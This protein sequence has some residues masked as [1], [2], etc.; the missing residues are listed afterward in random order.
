VYPNLLQ[1]NVI[2]IVYN[3]MAPALKNGDT[4]QQCGYGKMHSCDIKG[5][6]G[7][8]AMKRNSA[9]RSSCGTSYSMPFT[10][11]CHVG[12]HWMASMSERMT[13]S[14]KCMAYSRGSC[15]ER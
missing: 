3:C 11:R 5:E 15:Y 8:F 10:F 4:L 1:G 7:G 14:T 6:G 9:T 12:E 2:F 13:S